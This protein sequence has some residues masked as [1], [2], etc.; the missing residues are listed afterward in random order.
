MTVHYFAPGLSLNNDQY[1]WA[2]YAKNA[3][4]QDEYHPQTETFSNF[5]DSGSI[6]YTLIDALDSM[7]IMGLDKEYKEAYNWLATNHTFER[8]GRFNTFEVCI[9]SC[10][11]RTASDESSR[12]PFASSVDCCL[13]TTCQGMI[14]CTFKKRPIL[15]TGFWV[16]STARPGFPGPM[17]TSCP[18]K[19][20]RRSLAWLAS[21]RFPL[22][23]WSSAT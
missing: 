6:G 22:C 17:S 16:H 4:G 18:V 9:G 20:F 5:A 19:A 8:R 21:P 23:N 2:P 3:L 15:A 14:L 1:A 13:P 7:Q 12:L 10:T 11:F